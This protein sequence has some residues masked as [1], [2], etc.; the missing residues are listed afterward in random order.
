MI[1]LAILVILLTGRFSLFL[2]SPF[3]YEPDPEIERTFHQKRKKQRVEG[4]RRKAQEI[5]PKM[6]P[7]R[8]EP[9][10]RTLREFITPEVQ[11][12]TSSIAR[13]TLEVNDFEL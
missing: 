1:A 5:S 7:P 12:I 9:E 10:R 4:Q 11:G 3:V 6:E 8:R 2:R 13:P